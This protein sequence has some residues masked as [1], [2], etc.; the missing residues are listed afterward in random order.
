MGGRCVGLS[1]ER[2]VVEVVKAEADLYG[3]WV[4]LGGKK[5]QSSLNNIL[6]NKSSEMLVVYYCWVV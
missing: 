1:V 5:N 4:S 2:C 6:G 3:P